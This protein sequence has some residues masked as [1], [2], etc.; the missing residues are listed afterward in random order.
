MSKTSAFSH[1]EQL[2]GLGPRPLGSAAN[3]TAAEAIRAAFTAAGLTVE[4][5]PFACP[6]WTEES[7]RLTLAGASLP[8]AANPFSPAC[9]VTAPALALGTLTELER[10]DLRGRIAL[11]HGELTAN[12][13]HGSRHA[14]YF[15]E[16]SQRLFQLLEE[17]QPAAFIT[18]NMKRSCHERL[19]RDW[20]LQL[21]SATVTM[22]TGRRLLQAAGQPL[23]LEIKT[24]QQPAEFA[25]VIARLPGSL[26][27]EL[28]LMAHFDTQTDTPGA[29][30]NATGIGVLLELAAHFAA[31]PV[32]PALTFAA[33]NGEES[34]G[35]GSGLY[36]REHTAE[37]GR[38]IAAINIDG[39]AP[40]VGVTCITTMNGSEALEQQTR[41]V[42]AR[43][44]A[45]AWSAPWYAGD[46]SAFLWQGVPAVALTSI[47]Q[48]DINHY[49]DDTPDWVS[50]EKLAETVALVAEVVQALQDQTPAWSRAP[51]S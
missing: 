15:P 28:I 19:M 22:E 42:L 7:T 20:E 21:P 2:A 5:Q 30:D 18:I 8:A 41:A 47:G 32:A 50:R 36:T 44:P 37:M 16:T 4:T 35:V 3:L 26:P 39:V 13:G 9:D 40:A 29:Y 48:L 51:Q 17:K 27:L 33:F 12:E 38:F 6:L 25:N 10:A 11:L 45:V 34:G 43:Y 14:V 31:H 49:P 24:Q 1:M 23:H 46:H